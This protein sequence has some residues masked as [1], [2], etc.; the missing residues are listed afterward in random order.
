MRGPDFVRGALTYGDV[1]FVRAAVGGGV[2]HYAVNV[3]TSTASVITTQSVATS[4]PSSLPYLSPTG[5]RIGYY[6][7]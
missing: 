2:I 6:A 7:P 3:F 1:C 5:A 4:S